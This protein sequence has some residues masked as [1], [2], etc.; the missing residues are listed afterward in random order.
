MMDLTAILGCEP[1]VD[2]EEEAFFIFSQDIPSQSLGFIDAQAATLDL[3]VAGYDLVIH[4]SRGLLTSD[5]KTGTTGAVWAITPLLSTWLSS[6]S[7]PF[8]KHSLLTPKSS[9]LELGAG[10]SGILALTLGP[11]VSQYTATDQSYVLKLLRQN[12][13]ENLNTVFPPPK[14]AGRGSNKKGGSSSGGSSEGRINVQALDWETDTPSHLSPVDMVVACDCIYNE[15]LI[16]PL[17]SMC[18]AICTLRQ[19]E[20]G[21]SPTLCL[22]AQQLRSPDVFEAWIKNFCA[23]F[24]VWRV[25]DRLLDV[26]LREGSGFV[27]H[28]GVLKRAG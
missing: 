4:Q 16:E 18:A 6:P 19:E 2:P 24:S 22:I 27:V 11:K 15:S 3:S 8:T 9:I 5:R 26:G 14:K 17:N 25:P 1:V 12:I 20:E 21:G 7:N 28:I 10:V 23:K 13:A